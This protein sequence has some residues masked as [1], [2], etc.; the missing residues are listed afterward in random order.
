MGVTILSLFVMPVLGIYVMVI[1]LV[2]DIDRAYA[3]YALI[4][5]VA[6]ILIKIVV[7][8]KRLIH[9]SYIGYIPA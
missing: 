8:S 3:Q 4:I 9:I 7:I 5:P 2:L 6:Y 1:L